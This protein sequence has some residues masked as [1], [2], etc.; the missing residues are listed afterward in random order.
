MNSDP[1]TQ[2]NQETKTIVTCEQCL[3]KLRI[4]QRRRKIRVTCPTCRHEFLY[5]YYGLGFSST[6]KKPL[7][8]GLIGSL[9]GAF[10]IELIIIGQFLSK[11][12]PLVYAMILIGTIG[13]G[14]GVVLETA[15][16]FFKKRREN[17]LHKLKVGA[18][19][20]L[21]GGMVSS[22][23]AQLAFG[24]I[25]SLTSVNSRT[26]LWSATANYGSSLIPIM[27]ARTVGWCTLGL[28]LGLSFAIKEKT[29]KSAK[30]G[31]IGGLVGGGIGGLL[32][33][34]LT[35]VV[36]FGEG[37]LGRLLGFSALGMAIGIAVFRYRI[38]VRYRRPYRRPSSASSNNVMVIEKGSIAAPILGILGLVLLIGGAFLAA[39]N[40][41]G[42]F[43][44]F[45]FAGFITSSIGFAML[46]AAMEM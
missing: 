14:L 46:G 5:Q 25:L 33:D 2:P 17:L 20:G 3:Q 15:E 1:A 44:T 24:G 31:A 11:A 34:P 37:T 9:P 10:L 43:P 41:T 35:L 7:L 39:G 26:P 32:F 40:I 27:I 4:P 30:S 23:F 36:P 29:S 28:L 13:T 22:I 16:G 42:A 45:P 6:H 19:I 12:N 8:V 38:A 21:I 18:S